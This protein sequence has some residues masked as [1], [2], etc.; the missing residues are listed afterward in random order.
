MFRD[1]LIRKRGN[2]K[3]SDDYLVKKI[4]DEVESSQVVH[5]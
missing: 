1:H 5:E 3:C 2:E 4:D